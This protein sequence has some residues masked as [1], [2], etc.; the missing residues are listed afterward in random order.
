MVGESQIQTHVGRVT[1]DTLDQFIQD[2]LS[3]KRYLPLILLSRD[4]WSEEPAVEPE[5]ILRRVLGLAN[6]FII[7]KRA[8]FEL[9]GELG[10]A[11][12]CFNG[13]IRVYWP[14]FTRSADP[15]NHPLFLSEKLEYH[16]NRGEAIDEHLFRVFSGIAALRFSE[17]HLTKRVRQDLDLKRVDQDAAL[18]NQVA[19]HQ[20]STAT[21]EEELLKSWGAADKLRAERDAAQFRAAELEEEIAQLKL[22]LAAIWE[23]RGDTVV[24]EE[25]QQATQQ[26]TSVADALHK[27]EK[28]WLGTLEIWQSAIESA[29]KSNFCRPDEVFEALDAMNQLAVACAVAK[30]GGQSVG[31]WEQFFESRG[32]KYAPTESQNTLNMYGDERQFKNKG[33]RKQMLRHLTLGGGDR[34]NCLQIYFDLDDNTGLIQIGY[35]GV[36]LSYYGQRT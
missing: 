27:A 14:G 12:S 35:C 23:Y 30:K 7:D 4:A 5:L 24:A 2:L 29:E 9:T 26:V 32:I 19:E 3:I 20:L 31:P 15:M 25:G 11:L 8:S 13:A 36:H 1:I 34:S 22:N 18:R 28:Q 10:R 21:L 33:L 16:A 6:V 17:G